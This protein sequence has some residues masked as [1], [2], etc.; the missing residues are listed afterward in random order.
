MKRSLRRKS[1]RP[2]AALSNFACILPS[3][4]SGLPEKM[5]VI[6][7]RAAAARRFMRE[8]KT[9]SMQPWFGPD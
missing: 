3:F 9:P 6:L 1:Q 4:P 5:F 2:R 7:G 8:L